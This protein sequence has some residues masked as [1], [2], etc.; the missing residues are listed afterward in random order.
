MSCIWRSGILL[1]ASRGFEQSRDV[2]LEQFVSSDDAR[3]WQRKMPLSLPLQ[4]TGNLDALSDGR[5][6]LRYGNRC[7]NN[8]GVGVRFSEDQGET[9]I[10]PICIAETPSNRNALGSE[11][12]IDLTSCIR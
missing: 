3:A 2:H 10:P 4:V 9:W 1:A 7:W 12:L 5:A 8:F 11:F 6:L